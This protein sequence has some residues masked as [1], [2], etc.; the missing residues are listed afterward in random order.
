[1]GQFPAVTLGQIPNLSGK[2]PATPVLYQTE[3]AWQEK[4]GR[5]T[6][7][8]ANLPHAFAPLPE[9]AC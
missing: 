5:L 1:M 4:S 6:R 2:L 3:A 7:N 8:G 9:Y